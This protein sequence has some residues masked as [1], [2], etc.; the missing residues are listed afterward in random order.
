MAFLEVLEWLLCLGGTVL[1]LTLPIGGFM[2]AVAKSDEDFD[3]YPKE[4]RDRSY[5]HLE[6]ESRV[7][8]GDGLRKEQLPNLDD[9][10]LR[11]TSKAVQKECRRRW[12]SRDSAR[13]NV[14]SKSMG[15]RAQRAIE[16]GSESDFEDWTR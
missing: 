15:R 14:V 7:F 12:R 16:S 8:W 5:T 4:S 3:K 13:G 9:E 2:W 6:R 1:I 10:E 11:D